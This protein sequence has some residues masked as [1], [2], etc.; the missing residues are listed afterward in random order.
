MSTATHATPGTGPDAGS[1]ATPAHRFERFRVVVRQVLPEVALL[2]G[3]LLWWPVGFWGVTSW[4]HL[5][6]AALDGDVLL[7]GATAAAASVSLVVRSPWPRFVIVLAFSGL[8]WLLSAPAVDTYP[9]EHE[10]LAMLLAVGG[11]AGIVLGTRGHKGPLGAATVLAVVAGLSPA[12]WPDGL[13]LAVALALPF[14]VA[15]WQRV[16]PTLLSVARILVTWLVFALL[17]RSLSQGWD[18]LHPHLQAGSKRAELRL[19]TDASWEFLRTQWWHQ[20]EILLRATA[21]WFWVA[22]VLAVL[23][24][25]SRALTTG[26]N[27]RS[28]PAS[29]TRTTR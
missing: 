28:A 18:I 21:G 12:T 5:P 22:L 27:R 10:V 26:R 23:V 11:F 6:L 9:D 4:L 15:T 14:V 13:P 25:A 17:G 24:A 8:G 7:L 1:G 20:T 2:A 3:A 16:A 19:V 29:S